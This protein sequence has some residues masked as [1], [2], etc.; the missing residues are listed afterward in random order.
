MLLILDI[1]NSNIVSAIYQNGDWLQTDR[2][3]TDP[4]LPVHF[5]QGYFTRLLL[6]SEIRPERIKAICISSVVTEIT[7]SIVEAVEKYFGKKPFLIDPS[8]IIQLDMPVAKP[9]EIGSDLVANAYAVY[10]QMQNHAIVVDFGTALTFTVVSPDTGL[11]GV[12]IAPGLKASIRSL[13]SS[14]SRLP[15][16]PLVLPDSAIG[17]DTIHAIQAGVLYGYVGLVKEVTQRIRLESKQHYSL[18]ATG[19]LSAILPPLKDYFDIIDKNLTLNGIRLI[20]E[21]ISDEYNG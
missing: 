16:V 12:T 9:Y 17:K 11:M 5:Y 2:I 15:E 4:T 10:K 8:V 14:T 18:I 13:S 7:D 3:H 21:F 1:G 20:F 19:G 6:E